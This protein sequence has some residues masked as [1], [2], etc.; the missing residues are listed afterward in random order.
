MGVLTGLGWPRA[1]SDRMAAPGT[2]TGPPI[3]T[4]RDVI[5]PGSFPFRGGFSGP[6]PGPLD[7][8]RY[9]PATNHWSPLAEGPEPP[10][11]WCGLA[12]PLLVVG[13]G[14]SARSC[15]SH[16]CSPPNGR[17]MITSACDETTGQWTDFQ[18]APVLPGGVTLPD[19]LPARCGPA[20][21]C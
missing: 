6:A 5:E 1:T 15:P 17:A 12:R 21:G 19:S 10:T 20:R 16:N 2:T 9:D 7:A 11:R 13:E 3:W 8:H 14:T 18:P 4:G